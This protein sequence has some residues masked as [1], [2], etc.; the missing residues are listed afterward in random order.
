MDNELIRKIET[1]LANIYDSK[2]GLSKKRR[3]SLS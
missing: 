3:S 1:T 2:I